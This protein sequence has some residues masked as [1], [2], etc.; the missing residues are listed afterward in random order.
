MAHPLFFPMCLIESFQNV[1]GCSIGNGTTEQLSPIKP[2]ASFGF[3]LTSE[4]S[5]LGSETPQKF[6]VPVG[7]RVELQSS[8]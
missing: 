8:T 5:A 3:K 2:V 7:C 4:A 6:K 1:H